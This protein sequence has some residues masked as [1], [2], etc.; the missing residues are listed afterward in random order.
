MSFLA[1]LRHPSTLV[2]TGAVVL[3]V[4]GTATA[5]T[6]ITGKQIKNNSVTGADIRTSSLTGSD[7]KN[8]SLGVAD[9]SAAARAALKGAT[10]PAGPTGATGATG[11]AGAAGAKGDKGDKGDTGLTGAR[12]PS[13]GRFVRD[14]SATAVPDTMTVI[15]TLDLPPGTW[16]ITAAVRGAALA[17]ADHTLECELRNG[18]TVL[19]SGRDHFFEA[20]VGRAN[21]TL[22]AAAELD[23]FQVNANDVDLVCS[24]DATALLETHTMSAIEVETLTDESL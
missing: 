20:P 6:L 1:S 7:V 10:G 16:M 18:A 17:D 19:A 13:D 11:A 5:A 3:A 14:D 15:D 9:L 2:A 24:D 8:S 21:I 23:G 4:G 12:G 22:L